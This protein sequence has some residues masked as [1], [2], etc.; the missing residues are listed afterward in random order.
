MHWLTL[1]RPVVGF[2]EAAGILAALIMGAAC[3]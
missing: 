2:I 3:I 1:Q